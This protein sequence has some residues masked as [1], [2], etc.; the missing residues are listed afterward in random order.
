MNRTYSKVIIVTL[1]YVFQ[2]H[3]VNSNFNA[4]I[5]RRSDQ[6]LALHLMRIAVG[7]VGAGDCA[8]RLLI[9]YTPTS[10]ADSSHIN[11]LQFYLVLR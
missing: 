6:P 11:I 10:C 1:S 8:F 7:V 5:P 2:L 4:L 9:V 3:V